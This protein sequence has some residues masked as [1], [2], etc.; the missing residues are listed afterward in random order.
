MSHYL[1]VDFISSCAS[2][3]STL[4]FARASQWGWPAGM[5]STS[6]NAY[7]YYR[8][9][10]YG[11][12][13]LEALYFLSMFYGWYEWRHGG[14]QHRAL[15][16]RYARPRLK[17]L[18]VILGSVGIVI[19]TLFLENMTDSKVPLWDGSTTAV[20]LIG[21][22]LTCQKYME[23]WMVWFVVDALYLGL[24]VY[25]GVPFHALKMAVYLVIALMGYWCWRQLWI[26]QSSR[27]LYNKTHGCSI[28]S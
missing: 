28:S 4:F 26:E 12:L 15:P 7:L 18:L 9:G 8:I 27:S 23:C 11:E 21:Q 13:G 19:C 2:L 14:R 1:S 6:V 25:K 22:W 20:S 3:I 5:V 16:I 17:I 10:L 24:Y